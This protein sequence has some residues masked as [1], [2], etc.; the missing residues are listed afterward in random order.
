M[1]RYRFA[2]TWALPVPPAAVYAVLSDLGT[3]PSWWREV[4][5]ATRIDE[6]SCTLVCRSLLPYDLTFAVRQARADERAL[7]LEAD[8]RGDLE[9]VSR[10]TLAGEAGRCQAHFEEEVVV[11]KALLRLLEPVGRPAFRANH[12][13]MMRSGE[14]GLRRYLAPA[15][16]DR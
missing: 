10:W 9:G 14:R 8:L 6:S 1:H 7:V 2:S 12:A 13:L 4:R 5:R 3:Y 11:N 16:R 15:G